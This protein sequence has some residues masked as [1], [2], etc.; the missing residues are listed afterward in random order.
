MCFSPQPRTIFPHRNFGKCS[1]PGSFLTFWVA[2]VLLATAACNFSH[3][4]AP[5]AL[6]SLLF[7]PQDPQIF[8]KT[9][10]FATFLTFRAPV[11]SFFWFFFFLSSSLLLCFSS[12]HIVGSL[13]S[14]LTLISRHKY[15][16]YCTKPQNYSVER[17]SLGKCILHIFTSSLLL[18]CDASGH[19]RVPIRQSSPRRKH[20][21]VCKAFSR[22]TKTYCYRLARYQKVDP[23]LP[24]TIF[25]AM[26]MHPPGIL[27]W[28]QWL[29][30][31]SF[32]VGP[33]PWESRAENIQWPKP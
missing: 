18:Q 17:R 3:G 20:W 24:I 21:T 30:N 23:G 26:V 8:G 27:A 7:D 19:L 15:E 29:W 2:N 10:C 31:C 13:T 9:Q 5:A 6:A 22:K 14:K 32:L 11:S 33:K 25:K 12:L 16:N 28:Q 1:E 4:S